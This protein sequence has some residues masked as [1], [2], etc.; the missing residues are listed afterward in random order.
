MK[1]IN[2]SIVVDMLKI[3]LHF[4]CEKFESPILQNYGFDSIYLL[5]KIFLES[6]E[7]AFVTTFYAI[8]NIIADFRPVLR[9]KTF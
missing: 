2:L 1:T 4:I 3:R 6:S 5:H 7:N 9:V 8:E